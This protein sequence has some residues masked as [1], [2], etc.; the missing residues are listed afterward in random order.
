L[1]AFGADVGIQGKMDAALNTT[2]STSGTITA[3]QLCERYGQSVCRFAAL[4]AGS[5]SDADDL[6]QEAL[7]R[8]VRSLRSYDASRGSVEAWLWRIV[9]NAAKDSASRRQRVLDLIARMG[10]AAI[11]ES[12]SVEDAVLHRLRDAELHAQM[13]RLT[14]RDRT[15]L[16]LRFGA[17]LDTGQ[18]GKA[19]GLSPDSAAKAI[20]RALARLR[21]RLEETPR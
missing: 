6:A 19:I 5:S 12:E 11:T 18:V 3:E 10:F 13:R 4:A 15:V 20:R 9:A 17:G 7:L 16:A 21:A 2:A 1:S 14:L 8:A